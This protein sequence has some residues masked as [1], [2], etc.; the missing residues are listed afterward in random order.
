MFSVLDLWFHTYLTSLKDTQKILINLN[1]NVSYPG[2]AGV[3][4]DVL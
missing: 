3:L 2:K 4:L 1:I